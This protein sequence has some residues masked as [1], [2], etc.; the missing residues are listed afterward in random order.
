MN[1]QQNTDDIQQVPSSS[2]NLKT[3][4]AEQ[5]QSLIP[6]VITDGKVDS[7]KLQELLDKDTADD[8]ERFGL[9][10]P[11]KKRAMRA[12]QIP[13]TAT[14]KP[15]IDESKDWNTTQNLF[16]EGDNLEVLKVLQ[17]NYHNKI[18]MIYTDPPYNTGK[19]FVYP[20]NYKEGLASYLEFTKQVDKEGRKVSTNSDTDGRYH[21]NWINMMYPRLKLARNLLT[22]DGFIFVSIDD[23]E[24]NNLRLIMNEIFGENNFVDCL[25]W[26]KRY[27]GGAKEKHFVTLHEYVLVYARSIDV[28]GEITIP[29]TEESI[30]RYYTQQDE[31]F[32]L[33]G[34][35]RTHP[36]E[37]T[38]SMGDRPN[39][40]FPIKAPD[41]S[42]VSPQ[43][44][45]LWA[46]ETV[47]DAE[48]R[49]EL[50]FFKSESGWS[51]HTKQ[52][53]KDRDGKIRVG[54]MQS[55]VD[56]VF[57]QHGTNEII[58]LFG[59]A[60]IF[61][62]PKPTTFITKLLAAATSGDDIVL[63]YFSGSGSTA[64][65]VMK[66]NA[67]DNSK[68][69]H[70]QVQLPEPIEEN[71]VAYKA[72]YRTIADITKE[73]IRRAGVKIKADNVDVLSSRSDLLDLGF[74]VYKLADSNFSK[75]HTSSDVDVDDLQQRLIG[76]R[77]SSDDNASQDDL[78]TEILLKLGVSLTTQ[79]AQKDISGLQVWDVGNGAIAAYLDE[80]TK[81]NLDQL[82]AIAVTA[83]AKF[84][85]LEDAFQGDDELKTNLSQ[86]CKTNKIELWTV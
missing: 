2:P 77:E 31:N 32:D 64:H 10:W 62:F 18:K 79:A 53:L 56:D 59:D 83:P 84:V 3:E 44:Q 24:V 58:E 41:G 51:I 12:A 21:S 86:I 70:I 19:D 45:W 4:L 78:L 46:R 80:H 54:K 6:E 37:A 30:E 82:R 75:W 57:S 47:A 68:R 14:L 17:K 50:Q 72:G 34:P 33:R 85:I 22:D 5:L 13:T 52:Y 8:S 43:R 1:E 7:K 74:R 69:S 81:P 23:N 26:K 55:V 25:V 27:G 49:G 42:M 15:A 29:L 35:F 71:A 63:D 66:L 11:G 20:D 65:A 73:R 61:P 40:K 60:Q 76:M 39:L 48:K 16:I 36:L 9:F 38:K 28:V 67:E